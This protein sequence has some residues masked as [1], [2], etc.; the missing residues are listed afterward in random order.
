MRTNGVRS[1]DVQCNQCWPLTANV[2][3]GDCKP[4]PR[5]E[6]IQAK[7]LTKDG[8]PDRRSGHGSALMITCGGAASTTRRT[9]AQ[10]GHC[11]RCRYWTGGGVDA[12]VEV[13]GPSPAIKS[14]TSSFLAP[15]Q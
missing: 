12:D 10:M 14:Q 5:V 7:V 15:S 4:R 9:I 11:P 3:R 13:A 2:A 1:L 6:A 8:P